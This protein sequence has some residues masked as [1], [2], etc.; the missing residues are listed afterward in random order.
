MKCVSIQGNVLFIILIAVSLFAALSYSVVGGS[1]SGSNF[2]GKDKAKIDKA[3]IDIYSAQINMGLNRLKL[4]NGCSTVDYTP[5]ELQGGGDKTC[6]LYHPEGGGVAYRDL[7]LGV[8]CDL[9][10]LS[11]GEI[12]N[13]V[14][15]VGNAHGRRIY[16]SQ[17]DVA[18]S[19][20]NNGTASGL[21]GINSTTD[22][23]QNT[24][25]MLA[26]NDAQYEAAI[27]CRAL[28]EKWY[29]PTIDELNL[30]YVKKDTGALDG[31][32]TAECSSN[33]C[34]YFTSIEASA[35]DAH[36]QRFGDGNQRVIQK[37]GP[38]YVRCVR[39]D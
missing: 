7:G 21:T 8:G 38:R 31:S 34:Y 26:L 4:I 6:H 28:G 37:V 24:N 20:W 19:N 12:C 33:G 16:T 1:R 9:L 17:S 5:P 13:G 29:L 18:P 11:E 25:D 10:A 35:R 3:E 14:I 27:N 23:M 39:R 15:F 2:L 36:V 22:G 30:L 32:F